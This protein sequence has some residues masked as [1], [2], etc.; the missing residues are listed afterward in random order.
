ML[1][2]VMNLTSFH[3]GLAIWIAGSPG[4]NGWSEAVGDSAR[5]LSLRYHMRGR[6]RLEA[7]EDQFGLAGDHLW[8]RASDRFEQMGDIVACSRKTRSSAL[9]SADSAQSHR[10]KTE[11]CHRMV[12][13][14]HLIGVMACAMTL[15]MLAQAQ[16]EATQGAPLIHTY[17]GSH[18]DSVG[19]GGPAVGAYLDRPRHAFVDEYGD[20][21]IAD[22]GHKRIRRVDAETGL[23]ETVPLSVSLREPRMVHV[24]SNGNLYIADFMDHEIL[25]LQR[26]TGEV[27]TLVETRHP[28]AFAVDGDYLYFLRNGGVFRRAHTTGDVSLVAP[29]GTTPYGLALDGKGQIYV[30]TGS[31]VRRIDLV[32]G[33]YT[34][35][36]ESPTRF[37]ESVA[38]DS[39]GTVY[40]ADANKHVI[41]AS[42]RPGSVLVFSGSLGTPG[43]SGDGG[44]ASE[45]LLNSPDRVTPTA[46]G[47]LLIADTGNNRI[48]RVDG[49]T[50]TITTI[51][52][53]NPVGDGGLASNARLKEP[54]GLAVDLQGNLYIADLAHYRVRKVD[55]ASG[56]ISTVAGDGTQGQTGSGGPATQARLSQP[57][58][59]DVDRDGNVYIAD[60]WSHRVVRVDAV[61]GVLTPV[62]GT[63][64]AQLSNPQSVALDG[65]GHLFIADT[66]NHRVLRVDLVTGTIETVAGDGVGGFS[67]DGG[68]ATMAS[69][70]YPST[71]AIAPDGSLYILDAN[72]G[73]VRRVDPETAIIT[74]VLQGLDT[75][76]GLAVDHEGNLFVADTY[77]HRVL[78]VTPGGGKELVAGIGTESYN[79]DGI[80][81]TEA[82]IGY[83]SGLAVDREGTL[84]ISDFWNRRVRTV[85]VGAPDPTAVIDG[86]PR[87][88]GSALLPGYPNPFNGRVT[89]PFRLEREGR[90][91]VVVYDALGSPVRQLLDDD[92]SAGPNQIY[93]DGRDDRGFEVASGVY[94]CR[95][96]SDHRSSV[97][98]LLL[99]R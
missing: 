31:Q 85:A 10:V 76:E 20:L 59:V 61:T 14:K 5:R 26:A 17:A 73:R 56:L 81:A 2:H 53:A 99:L 67:G 24:D 36:I 55:R 69:L 49:Q 15:A 22:G 60:M 48:R 86:T 52:G 13:S 95:L 11:G 41:F 29:A 58:D 27:R 45:A 4:W 19:D 75:K 6:S 72:N 32:S 18:A 21:Y 68:P 79:G 50:G 84:Y 87:P 83:P 78:R 9:R 90:I 7:R 39:S 43:L 12:T 66:F 96:L 64:E 35:W 71:L 1:T 57:T 28:R 16:G 51:V 77:R 25:L 34:S 63:T 46:D 97:A 88:P 91:H 54:R 8:E 74:T 23:I 65:K 82:G 93:W 3:G 94:M 80:P 70:Q 38:V 89:I 62:V 92:M 98:K 44:P 37:P 30:L 40:V 42:A 33:D 47:D